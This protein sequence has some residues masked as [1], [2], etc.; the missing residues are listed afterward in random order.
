MP[1]ASMFSD[2]QNS[3]SWKVDVDVLIWLQ[4]SKLSELCRGAERYRRKRWVEVAD[5]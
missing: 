3:S 5:A 2:S 4:Q 1:I